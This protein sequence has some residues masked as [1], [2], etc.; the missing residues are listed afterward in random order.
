MRHAEFEDERL[1]EVYDAEC[2]WGPDDDWFV[3]VAGDEP[4]RVLDLGCGT[5]RV[6]LA[7]AAAGHTVTGV[8]PA[9]ASL[10]A[11]RRKPGADR[12]AWIAGTSADRPDEPVDVA[13]MSS[14]VAQFF[15]TD[16]AWAQVLADLAGVV[17]PGGRLAFDSR[18]PDDRAWERWGPVDSKRRIV[19]AD[20]RVVRAETEV[21]AMDRAV[22]DFTHTYTFEDGTV[23]TSEASLRFRSRDE[24]ADT[25]GDAGFALTR[26]DGPPGDFWVVATRA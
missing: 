9:R 15:T 26:V 24:L 10:A 19:L 23:L 16:E 2:T 1:V 11:A 8:D 13:I 4:V 17:V 5:G 25:L 14:H 12:V 18:D 3:G 22:V 20:G 6:T 21:T 7:L